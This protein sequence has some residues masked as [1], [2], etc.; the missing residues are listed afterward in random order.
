NSDN[1]IDSADYLLVKRTCLNTYSPLQRQY[2]SMDVNS[3]ETVTS[4]DYLFVKRHVFKTF[5]LTK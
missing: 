4:L 3:D 5:D 2:L 1:V